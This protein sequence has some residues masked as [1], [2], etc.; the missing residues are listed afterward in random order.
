MCVYNNSARVYMV[1]H[2]VLN[3]RG[4]DIIFDTYTTVPV[5]SLFPLSLSRS[6]NLRANIVQCVFLVYRET[7][8]VYGECIFYKLSNYVYRREM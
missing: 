6:R 5:Q 4:A 3:A 1:D 8:S 7:I 2:G